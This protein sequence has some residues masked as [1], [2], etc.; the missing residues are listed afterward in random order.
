M[1]GIQGVCWCAATST[2]QEDSTLHVD[3][4]AFPVQLRRGKEALVSYCASRI[5]LNDADD[6]PNCADVR[7]IAVFCNR[8]TDSDLPFHA[9]QFPFPFNL[10]LYPQRDLHFIM[11]SQKKNKPTTTPFILGYDQKAHSGAGISAAACTTESSPSFEIS[12][13]TL[14][15]WHQYC[16][17]IKEDQELDV[18]LNL[19]RALDIYWNPEDTCDDEFVENEEVETDLLL[20]QQITHGNEGSGVGA[21]GH[22]GTLAV[23]T[24]AGMAAGVGGVLGAGLIGVDDDW[25]EDDAIVDALTGFVVEP[26]VSVVSDEDIDDASNSSS[27]EH[28]DEDEDEEEDDDCEADAE[29]C[30]DDDDAAMGINLLL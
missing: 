5:G 8:E 27:E 6:E 16:S 26:N 15:A 3:P 22:A 28:D 19:Q 10:P 9:S 24:G 20:L 7:W 17:R 2:W 18:Y 12:P 1:A 29:G 11:Y 23:G 30:A 13:L 21:A 14:K 4:D 25:N